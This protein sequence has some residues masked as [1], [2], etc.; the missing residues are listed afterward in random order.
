MHRIPA[1]AL[2]ALTALAACAAPPAPSPRAVASDPAARASTPRVAGRV[3][4]P[5]GAAVPGAVA[6]LVREVDLRSDEPDSLLARADD[7]GAFAFMDVAPG[8]YGLTATG[9]GYAAGYGGVVDVGDAPLRDLS[10]ALGVPGVRYTGVVVDERG[11]VANA[12]VSV[13]EY[14]PRERSTYTT[15]TGADG[16]YTIELAPGYP[17]IGFVAAPPRM[18]STELF[19]SGGGAV[20]F[21][22]EPAPRERPSDAILRTYL[23]AN[24]LPIATDEPEDRSPD[25]DAVIALARAARVVAIGEASHGA[26]EIFRLRH[27]LLRRFIQQRADTVLGIEA[28]FAECEAIDAY[29]QGGPGD[30]KALLRAT[31]TDYLQ[32]E[33]W[34]E[35]LVA[36]RAH[37]AT[38]RGVRVHVQGFD[39]VSF[40]SVR[41]VVD[42]VRARAPTDADAIER[43]LAPL[44]GVDA[45]GTYAEASA[46]ARARVDETLRALRE[47]FA[48]D[49]PPSVLLHHVDVL[50]Q[51]ARTYLDPF[52]RDAAMADA[53]DWLLR[54]FPGERLV[55]SMHDTH[56]SKLGFLDT[57]LGR[58]LSR[59]LGDDYFVYGT[60]FARGSFRSLG[61]DMSQ[62]VQSFRVDGPEP[63][64]LEEALDLGS[65]SL[66]ALDLRPSDG[67]VPEWLG[68][69][70]RT[71]SVGFRFTGPPD[72]ATPTVPRRAY[73]VV[74][75]VREVSAAR[76]LD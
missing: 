29:V 3:V 34:R 56:A 27:R 6:A 51:A 1:A 15:L 70:M 46:D 30:P 23:D 39:V 57:Q 14:S 37:N 52:A 7:S 24:A 76:A 75:F 59:R 42:A 64:S 58:I 33:E 2:V 48:A 38:T 60:A 61:T 25:L 41:A 74:L 62:G 43:A 63:G 73:D 40:G 36:L 53:V 18:R 66:Y 49:P 11:P 12:A 5:S 9:A 65:S 4:S 44:A 13:V 20:D 32:T 10:I 8:R 35:L 69:S 28:P 47:R 22:L 54:R 68:G 31:M 67:R 17:Y 21:A 71:R 45:D 26:R 72:A 16:R 50:E 19:P 55:L